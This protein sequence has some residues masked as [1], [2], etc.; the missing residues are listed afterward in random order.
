[1]P[2]IEASHAHS[3]LQTTSPERNFF[4]SILQTYV[5]DIDSFFVF[6]ENC[7][8]NNEQFDAR[9]I[10]KMKRNNYFVENLTTILNLVNT[11]YKT[12]PTLKRGNLHCELICDMAGID[13]R[14]FQGRIHDYVKE[15]AK[16]Y[17][18]NIDNLLINYKNLK[19]LHGGNIK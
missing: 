7:K 5:E 18:F 6:V 10:T 13:Y 11:N 3:L 8:K 17:N 16:K 15:K 1:M 14:M 4:L 19:V 12:N 9:S 2:Q